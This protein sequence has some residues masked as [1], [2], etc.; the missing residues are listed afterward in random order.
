MDHHDWAVTACLM[1]KNGEIFDKKEP[2]K[3]YHIEAPTAKAA[4]ADLKRR[5]VECDVIV[6]GEPIHSIVTAKEYENGE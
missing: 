6:Y 2:F 4:I 5:F 1:F 3:T